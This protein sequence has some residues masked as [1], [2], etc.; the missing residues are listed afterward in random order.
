MKGI[1]IDELAEMCKQQQAQGNGK[2]MILMSSDDEGND[3]HHVWQ[4]FID[5]K[6]LVGCIYGYQMVNCLTKNPA[7]YIFLI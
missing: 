4:G 7:N 5:G 3:Y 1:T 6:E 2:K